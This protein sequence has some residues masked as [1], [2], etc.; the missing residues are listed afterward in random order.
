MICAKQQDAIPASFISSADTLTAN[1]PE[2]N[3]LTQIDHVKHLYKRKADNRLLGL[4]PKA[5][6]LR[7]S[8]QIRFDLRS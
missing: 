8:I 2:N 3:N 4:N 7:K 6:N 5:S 1:E